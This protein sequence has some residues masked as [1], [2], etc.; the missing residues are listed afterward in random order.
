MDLATP[1][2]NPLILPRQA[3]FMATTEVIS[4]S[5]FSRLGKSLSGILG[6]LVVF[7]IS[8]VLLAWNEGRAVKTAKGLEEGA[9]SVASLESVDRVNPEFDGRLVHLGGMADGRAM[10][11]DPEFGIEVAALK[12]QRKVEMLQWKEK[13][14]STTRNKLGG[15]TETVTTYTYEKIW[16]DM[17]IDSSR[18]KESASHQNPDVMPLESMEKQAESITIGAFRLSP[19]LVG[20]L[21]KFEDIPLPEILPEGYLTAGHAI[22]K[23]KNPATPQIGDLRITFKAAMPAEVSV[24]ARQNGSQL[25]GFTTR[26]GTVLQ[27]LEYGKVT[28]ESM[29][30]SAK[31]ANK[32]LTWGLRALGFI[33]LFLAA[34]S[35]LAPIAVLADVL[36]FAGKIARTGTSLIAALVALPVG[37]LTI[38]IAW[39]A[40]RPLLGITLLAT[41]VAIPVILFL[42]RKKSA[43]AVHA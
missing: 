3:S 5:W 27:M 43:P 40:Y 36:P 21:D 41:G 23:S 1:V 25:E 37:L 22:F 14:E 7:M 24:I 19:G 31:S 8:I 10:L 33:L 11:A 29:F 35:V 42:A 26:T 12:L 39:I 20:S 13:S 2:A 9:S 16:S 34:K 28:A 17:R 30:A 15:G 6:G 38:A 18:F 32:T 4:Q